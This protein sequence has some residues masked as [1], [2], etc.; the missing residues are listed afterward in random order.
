[1]QAT[2]V[3]K[4]G[5]DGVSLG[6]DLKRALFPAAR[7]TMAKVMVS[8]FLRPVIGALV[9]ETKKDR[10]SIPLLGHGL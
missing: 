10:F 4:Q 2:A 1:M 7:I 3:P 8:P 6:R 5:M 9:L